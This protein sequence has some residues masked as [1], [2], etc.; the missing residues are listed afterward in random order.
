MVIDLQNRVLLPARAKQRRTVQLST[1]KRGILKADGLL[2]IIQHAAV[3]QR[4]GVVGQAQGIV[5]VVGRAQSVK[6]LSLQP[7]RNDIPAGAA[8]GARHAPAPGQ[9]LDRFH[10]LQ[11][12]T[13]V[14]EQVERVTLR[15]ARV[16]SVQR[17][18]ALGGKRSLVV[19]G[20]ERIVRRHAVVG[21][22]KR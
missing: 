8:V 20:G 16:Q 5:L 14:L 12:G 6:R 21:G 10:G 22:P 3:P 17:G 2:C 1:R 7:R 9:R 15:C 4:V 13:L 11:K 18:L 19:A